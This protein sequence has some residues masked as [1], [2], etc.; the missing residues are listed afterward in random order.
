MSA[1]KTPLKQPFFR[2]AKRRETLRRVAPEWIGTPFFANSRAKGARG[3][4]D[5]VNLVQEIFLECGLV[6]RRVEFPPYR[7][8]AGFHMKRSILLTVLRET[9]YLM[10]KFDELPAEGLALEDLMPG[11]LFTAIIGRVYH[12]A[13]I[14]V[15]GDRYIN[16]WPRLGTV[17]G[18]T[19]AAEEVAQVRI[20]RPVGR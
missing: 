7:I 19:Q 5:C 18:H 20:F 1:K 4:V 3:G 11:D 8:D 15:E 16:A 17:W 12:H 14:L 6:S 13:A 2:T 10:S 9:P